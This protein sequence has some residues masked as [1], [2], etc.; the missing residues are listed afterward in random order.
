M[1]KISVLVGK[2]AKIFGDG[3]WEF[4]GLIE[5]DKK[6][7]IIL[8]LESQ[9]SI[10]IFKSHISAILLPVQQKVDRR[11]SN[12]SPSV[13]DE[14][15]FMVFKPAQARNREP[16]SVDDLSEG[17]VSLPHEVLL[18]IRSEDQPD[19]N[20]FSSYFG[21]AT[22]PSGGSRLS[23]TLEGDDDSE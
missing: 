15:P 21:A 3:G 2:Q 16:A 1:K 7:R 6:D 10:L 11:K 12:A 19:D 20:I 23:V 9:D 5:V 8:T 18:G 14:S 4:S 17:G 22:D 13:G